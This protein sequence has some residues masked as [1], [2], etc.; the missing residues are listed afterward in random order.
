MSRR[1]LVI[2]TAATVGGVSI[3]L[4]ALALTRESSTAQPASAP[5]EASQSAERA[6][7][8]HGGTVLKNGAMVVEMVL[9]EKPGDARL[10][11]YPAIDGKPSDKLSLIHI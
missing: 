2:A 9:S 6:V 5:V 1:K 3:A 8:Q 4:A 7:G 11:V 10:V